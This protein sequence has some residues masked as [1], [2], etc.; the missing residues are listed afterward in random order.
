MSYTD[1]KDYSTRDDVF[2]AT[3]PVQDEG[4]KIVLAAAD[5]SP[6]T[7]DEITRV[8][9]KA[10]F[11]VLPLLCFTVGL[12]YCD[13]SALSTAALFGIIQDLKLY[14]IA[15]GQ[16]DTH[17]YS[18]CVMMAS[19]GYIIG[20][21]PLAYIAQKMPTGKACAVYCMVW[22]IVLILTP[23][24][25]TYEG[26]LAQRFFLGF[27]EAGVSPAFLSILGM[28][29][30]AREQ[31]LRATILFSA[32]G[33]TVIPLLGSAYGLVTLNDKV[34]AW[35]IIYLFLGSLTI[36]W[37][38]L[39]AILVPDSPVSARFL[40]DRAK[41]VAVE[42]LRSN[43]AGIT[44]KNFKWHQVRASALDPKVWLLGIIIFCMGSPNGA[45]GSFTPLVI[46]NVYGATARRTLL[47][48]MPAATVSGVSN[49]LAGTLTYL[50]PNM[51][52]ISIITLAVITMVGAALEWKLPFSD[53]EGLLAALYLMSAFSGALGATTGLVTSN[54]A[55][56]SRKTLVGS[57]VFMF[58]NASNIAAPFFFLKQEQPRYAS[59]FKIT[60]ILLCIGIGCTVIY[61]GLCLRENK[62]REGLPKDDVDRAFDDLTDLDNT[63]FRYKL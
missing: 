50:V 14:D 23:L 40:D 24:C 36:V 16:I 28:W 41:F 12:Q 17:A 11:L 38:V 5:A 35:K 34:A 1:D 55:G 53:K 32:N 57:I 42:R 8:R 56:A 48:L 59:G 6:P 49:L 27:F 25:K 15:G 26:L 39:F 51:R 46:Q 29:Y 9:R 7:E 58:L 18:M 33:L 61:A 60:L 37:A 62:R 19:V 13:K 52:C 4:A 63:A 22:G 31:A 10:D 43:Q 3:G 20:T 30:T 54:T 21:F 47:L 44:S 45:I 2:S